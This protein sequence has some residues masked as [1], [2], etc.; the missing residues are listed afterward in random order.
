MHKK[1]LHILGVVFLSVGILLGVI[2][3]GIY[4]GV[5]GHRRR[6]IADSD[7]V[8]ATIVDI[9]T[10]IHGSGAGTR[11]DTAII[12]YHVDGRA[13]QSRLNHWH[14]GMRVGQSVQIYVNRQDPY[15]FVLARG[16]YW[17]PVLVLGILAVVF[18]SIGAGFLLAQRHKRRRAQW[19]FEY[20]TPVWA[21]V[22]GTEANWRIQ[23]NGR[24]ATVLVATYKNMRFVSSALD[25]NDLV[26]IGTHVKVLLHPHDNNKYAFDFNGESYLEPTEPPTP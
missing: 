26:N 15:S 24:P 20:G 23:I 14:S 7:P 19:L 13:I 4:V 3:V 12:E 22:Q 9:S 17:I 5:G 1:V 10:R 11:N 25:N 8:T 6:V 18:G 2:G 21:V 16:L